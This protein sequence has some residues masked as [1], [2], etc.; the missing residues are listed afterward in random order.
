MIDLNSG[1][2]A[3]LENAFPAH[4]REILRVIKRT[5]VFAATENE[6]KWVAAFS[7][8]SMVCNVKQLCLE[9]KNLE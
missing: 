2:D 3:Y 1:S 9:L 4:M 5:L 6:T 7:A 8:C